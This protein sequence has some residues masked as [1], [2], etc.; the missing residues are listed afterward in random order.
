MSDIRRSL[1]TLFFA[2]LA[3]ALPM[4]LVARERPFS[5][6]SSRAQAMGMTWI[7]CTASEDA[8]FFNPAWL[9]L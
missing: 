7:A 3:C 5:P 1:S 6:G 4:A 9:A 2:F 8:A